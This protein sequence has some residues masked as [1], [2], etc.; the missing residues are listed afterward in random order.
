MAKKKK[1]KGKEQKPQW[2]GGQGL[3]LSGA[4]AL[5]DDMPVTPE[6]IEQLMG[7]L[8]PEV[9]QQFM[10]M[11]GELGDDTLSDLA[12][13]LPAPP[14]S[15]ALA[16]V[17][18]LI[19][20]A[21]AQLTSSEAI[22]YLRQAEE[23]ARKALGKRFDKLAGRF[24]D[25]E[26]GAAFIDVKTEL[27]QALRA[28]G[29]GEAALAEV[30]EA[31]RLDPEAAV[32]TRLL[33]LV[34]Y[35]DLNRDDDAQ[36]FLAEH[37]PEEWAAWRFGHLLL[38]LRRGVRGSEVDQL[39]RD[40]HTENPYVLS[41]LIGA[42]MPEAVDPA[43]VTPGED[44]E[45]QEYVANFLAAWK[46]TPGAVSWLREAALRLNLAVEPDDEE[47]PPRRLTAREYARL[48]PHEHPTWIAGLHHMPSLQLTGDTEAHPY[49]LAFAFSPDNDMIGFDMLPER[50]T[51]REVWESLVQF[52]Q[53]EEHPG[54]PAK[55]LLQPPELAAKLK[56]EAGKAKIELEPY[57]DSGPLTAML[58]ELTTRMQGGT[59]AAESLSPDAIRGA[60]LNVDEVWEAAV[61]QLEGR[62][63]I[64]G[65]SLRPWVALVMARPSGLILWHELFTDTPPSGALAN[66]LRM[67]IVRPAVGPSRRPREVVVRDHDEA[68][69][70]SEL[71]DEAGFVGTVAGE[72]P[73][74]TDAIE[75][76]V[77][78][79][80]GGERP[81]VLTKAEGI[82]PADLER[83]YTAAADFY[84]AQPWKRF[85]MDEVIALELDAAREKPRYA[86]VMGQSGITQ[87]LAI[88]F[89]LADIRTI[90]ESRRD[91]LSFDSFS[92]MFGED[93][94]IA[95]ADLDAIEQFGCPVATP[96]A[97]PDALRVFPG[98]TVETPT[99]ADI[100]FISG[101][102]AAVAALAR[103]RQQ[104]SI[105]VGEAGGASVKATR[106]GGF[107]GL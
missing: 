97:Y 34:G 37:C 83:F 91:D 3:P 106:L 55:L 14:R 48:P 89:Q 16:S 11:L 87:G 6:M 47:P 57:E 20:T 71:A 90:F 19:D 49:W 9:Q 38:T 33:M 58:D 22:P 44:S 69:S 84:R 98:Q 62:L 75:S 59:K 7:M 56:K 31:F 21:H 32:E 73:L 95:P 40:A 26:A 42:R 30:E 52:M 24:G 103:D 39:L 64:G 76:L 18:R 99:A 27:A 23:A 15:K 107:G 74:V 45:A 96:E 81:V 41:L 88:Y 60:P 25:E 93:S 10:Q 46:D 100:R 77:Q 92:I 72:L 53:D 104:R 105:T 66:A 63:N 5:P 54:R 82:T 8:P 13:E 65:Q 80:L 51:P 4:F 1:A 29:Q 67:A 70:L 36:R 94:S 79:F 12:T 78:E 17:D 85:A 68:L 35:L 86:L 2:T 50:P 102:L 28:A 43:D 101:A 61:V